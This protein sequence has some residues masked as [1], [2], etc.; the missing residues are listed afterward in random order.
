MIRNTT[1]FNSKIV[2][3]I[4]IYNILTMLYSIKMIISFKTDLKGCK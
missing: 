3:K 4:I 2:I 1:V